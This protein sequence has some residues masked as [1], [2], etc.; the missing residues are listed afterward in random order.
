MLIIKWVFLLGLLFVILSFV[1]N[2]RLHQYAAISEINIK[3]SE[4]QFIN[5]NMVKDFLSTSSNIFDDTVRLY[6][7]KLDETEDLLTSHPSIESAEVFTSNKGEICVN[8]EQKEPVV[9]VVSKTGG[10][11]LDHLGQ[12]MPLSDNYTAKL[13]VVSG[14]VNKENHSDIINFASFLNESS[15][16]K[17]QI[18]QL[19][20]DNQEVF[21]APR[22]GNHK[23]H[24]GQ[25]NKIKEKLDN[26]YHFYKNA[27]PVKG[28]QTY[29]DISLKYKN[30]IICTKK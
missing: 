17:S 8:I 29:S 22:I 24:F 28:W 4:N 30:Q 13:I 21:L 5:E 2:E 10:Y 3:A 19:H 16:W 12:V 9:R 18:T 27:M 11:Y 20:F 7:F 23:I 6:D 25:L 14:D 1:D 15:F 26:L